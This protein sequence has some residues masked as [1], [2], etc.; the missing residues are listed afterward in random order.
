[1][2]DE[3][4]FPV[5]AAPM[6]GGPT[7]PELVA[8]VT[9]AGGFGFL[10]AGMLT[11]A[12]LA[13]QID[14][15]GELTKS[16]FGVNLFVPQPDTGADISAHRE[17]LEGFAREHDVELG[18]PKWDDDA[19]AAKLDV[20]LEKRVPVVSFTF[21]PPSPSDVLRLHEAGAR[22]VVTVTS[23]QAAQRAAD[24]GA[25]ALVLQGFEAGGHRSL[26]TDD[27]AL[28][29][30]GAE[31][32]V[33]ALLRLVAGR[34][35]LPLVAAGG[36]V[37]GA[38]VAAVLAA[39]AAAAQLGTV[40]LRADEAGTA[41]AHRKALAVAERETAFTRA[42]SGR[43]ARGLVNKFMDELSEGAPAAYPQLNHLAGP[44]RKAS[45]KAGDPEAMSL[46]AGQTYPLG[47][48]AS[49]AVILERLKV[50][51]REAAARLDRIR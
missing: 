39:G 26:F 1:M 32:G 21:G 28:P 7:T 38:D 47:Y 2:F 10:A 36:L 31:Y 4:A 16:P 25:D 17:R 18:E 34:V 50:E 35:G 24:L 49:V 5:I 48:D 51:A 30:G 40:F 3:L 14:R 43:P 22:V 11:P 42:F 46:W 45:A 20:V 6:A 8:A 33:L 19:Y 15:T 27:A 44:V 23:P 12:A 9:E 13:A 41:E 37:H 29:G